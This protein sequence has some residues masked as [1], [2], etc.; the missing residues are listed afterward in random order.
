MM[1]GEEITEERLAGY[2]DIDCGQIKAELTYV[3]GRYE[4]GRDTKNDK[5]QPFSL[6]VIFDIFPQSRNSL[7]SRMRRGWIHRSSATPEV[8]EEGLGGG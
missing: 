6:E 3:A 8:S 4:Y 2:K 5:R 1:Q 7:R